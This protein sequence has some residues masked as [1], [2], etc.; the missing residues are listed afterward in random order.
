MLFQIFIKLAHHPTSQLVK[1]DTVHSQKH[2]GARHL[3]VAEQRFLQSGVVFPTGIHQFVTAA[4]SLLYHLDERGYFHEIRACSR[5]DTNVSHNS[6]FLMAV[7][8]PL[9]KRH[10]SGFTTKALPILLS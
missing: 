5:K 9:N 6:S 4:F 2:I 7:R 3:Q 1:I 10:S 8:Q